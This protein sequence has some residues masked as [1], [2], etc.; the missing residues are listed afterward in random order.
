MPKAPIPVVSPCWP[1]L[2]QKAL[3]SRRFWFSLPCW[4]VPNF[5]CALQDWSLYYPQ[6]S[7]N[8]VIKSHWPWRPEGSQSLC[9][10][11]RLEAWHGIQNLHN[12]VRAC[13]VLLF[14]ILWV[15]QLVI[16]V[17]AS[18]EI[19]CFRRVHSKKSN[20]KDTILL[21]LLDNMIR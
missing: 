6:S 19:H 18:V 16:P 9:Q 3:Y 11:P 8:S 21:I 1:T 17:T 20:C 10:I 14:S 5:V 15:T 13:L 4:C 2:L 12:S 7:G